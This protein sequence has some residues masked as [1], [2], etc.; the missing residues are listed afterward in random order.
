MNY[1]ALPARNETP[2]LDENVTP[3]DGGVES[4]Q[5]TLGPAPVPKPKPTISLLATAMDDFAIRGTCRLVAY[6]LLRYFQ[7]GGQVFPKVK[8]I[9]KNIGKSERVVQRQLDHLG[10]LGLWVRDGEAPVGGPGRRPNL[11]KM[12]L[13]GTAPV[14]GGATDCDLSKPPPR[15]RGDAHVTPE[16]TPTSPRSNH[17]EVDV[18][19][20]AAEAA[21]SDHLTAVEGGHGVQCRRCQ[22]SWPRA[23]GLAHICAGRRESPQRP[24]RRQ[25]RT[26]DSSRRSEIIN[27]ERLA[28]IRAE[29][30]GIV[31]A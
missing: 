1:S 9:A 18:P 29:P 23:A 25:G 27:R 26:S 2:K 19:P 15:E 10:R 22:H 17:R 14:S 3:Q 11:Y 28:R 20:P 7:P 5:L 31:N 13:P 30:R 8:T 4:H 21:L 24:P 6:E 16:V 12:R